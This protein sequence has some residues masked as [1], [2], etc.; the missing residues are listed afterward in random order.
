M[1]FVGASGN[2]YDT[3]KLF[4]SFEYTGTSVGFVITN[5]E[6]QNL[7]SSSIPFKDF[8]ETENIDLTGKAVY[9]LKFKRNI[10]SYTMNIKCSKTGA[11]STSENKVVNV[12]EP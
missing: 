11:I 10:T 5:Y 1:D 12:L 3:V 4:A 7:I 2:I 6:H 8:S 9:Q